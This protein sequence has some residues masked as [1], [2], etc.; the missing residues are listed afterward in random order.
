MHLQYKD[1]VFLLNNNKVFTFRDRDRNRLFTNKYTNNILKK[2]VKISAE[3]RL[4]YN[5]KIEYKHFLDY[6]LY[7]DLS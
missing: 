6:N 2:A 3:C 5:K 7:L 4:K 1:I